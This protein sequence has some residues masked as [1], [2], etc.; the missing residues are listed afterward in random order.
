MAVEVPALIA[1]RYLKYVAVSLKDSQKHIFSIDSAGQIIIMCA[2]ETEG[3][4]SGLR[5]RS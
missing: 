4:P 2:V 5:Q 3:W 1:V